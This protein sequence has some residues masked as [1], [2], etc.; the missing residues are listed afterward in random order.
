MLLTKRDNVLAFH[1]LTGMR[2]DPEAILLYWPSHL[3]PAQQGIQP[4]E[5]IAQHFS[6]HTGTSRLPS[7]AT[8]SVV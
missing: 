7:S 8:V 1:I 4:P 3:D 6:T 2:V 5:E